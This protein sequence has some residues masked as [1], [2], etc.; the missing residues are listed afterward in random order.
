VT[1]LLSVLL[2]AGIVY[3]LYVDCP[4]DIDEE[5]FTC[6]I[7]EVDKSCFTL[8]KISVLS[9]FQLKLKLSSI[10]QVK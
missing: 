5:I 3:Q 4:Q 10:I 8:F 7:D 2:I 6:V 9:A 1:D